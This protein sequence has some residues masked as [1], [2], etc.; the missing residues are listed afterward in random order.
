[1]RVKRK[2]MV[3]SSFAGCGIKTK[4]ASLLIVRREQKIVQTLF[5]QL[6]SPHFAFC[7]M[8]VAGK[9]KPNENNRN[10]ATRIPHIAGC[11]LI[12]INTYKNSPAPHI[13]G[14]RD[15]GLKNEISNERFAALRKLRICGLQD[16]KKIHH[17]VFKTKK[18]NIIFGNQVS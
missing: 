8:Q 11:R 13:C 1:M 7:G 15:A 16:V 12:K 9:H 5:N 18:S 3:R 10:F 14:M 6:R 4:F 2:R 17:S